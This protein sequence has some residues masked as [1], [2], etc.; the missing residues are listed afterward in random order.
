[1]H[2]K[3]KTKKTTDYWI[4]MI[5]H[6]MIILQDILQFYKNKIYYSGLLTNNK[7]SKT[8]VRNLSVSLHSGFL[9]GQNC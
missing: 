4:S 7:T 2:L 6:S 1:M 5:L 9:V 8:I 3:K